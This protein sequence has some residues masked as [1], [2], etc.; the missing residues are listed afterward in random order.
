MKK[1][2][3]AGIV[4]IMI[5]AAGFLVYYE[6]IDNTGSV[7]VEVA[8]APSGNVSAVY[9]TFDAVYMHSTTAGWK[10]F[11]IGAKTVNILHLS[12]SNASLLSSVNIAP[13]KYTMIRLAIVN[14]TVKIS[15]F[16]FAFTP[17]N[18]YVDI[19]SPFTVSAHSTT[20]LVID[21]NLTQDLNIRSQVFT[22]TASMVVNP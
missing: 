21:F 12:I 22:P 16:S 19:V 10:N 13:G 9:I 6:F 20:T 17:S 7:H 11:S 14:V 1:Q 8:D 5:I 2:V 3:I 4:A 15:G 18:G